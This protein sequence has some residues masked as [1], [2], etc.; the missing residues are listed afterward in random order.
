MARELTDK[1]RRILQ[2]IASFI[3]DVG[4]PPSIR[5]IGD[6][7]QISSLRGVTVHLDAL[8]K[9]G[10]IDRSKTPRSITIKH[11]QYQVRS[12]AVMLPLLGQVAAGLPI[13]SEENTERMIPVP[14]DMVKNVDQA[15]L[16]EVKGVSMTGDGIM[17]RDLVVVRSQP[18]VNRSDIAVV[19][20]G[21]EMTVKRMKPD[22]PV[23]RLISSNPDFAE[24]EHPAE[25]VFV[26]GRV[27]GLLRDYDNM[28]F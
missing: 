17:P 2:Y 16:L 25:D 26:I 19:R 18:T 7:F 9:K 27:I 22:G 6:H 14:G 21:D 5:E 23:V 10:Y 11:P 24:Q 28:A 4:Y 8:E 20:V 3:E 12:N 15:F 1:Q 13:F